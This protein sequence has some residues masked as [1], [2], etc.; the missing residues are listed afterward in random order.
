MIVYV[1]MVGRLPFGEWK[2]IEN[3]NSLYFVYL[4]SYDESRRDANPNGFSWEMC[5][6]NMYFFSEQKLCVFLKVLFRKN[7]RILFVSHKVYK[8]F[9]QCQGTTLDAKAKCVS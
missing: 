5:F 1:L 7:K 9:L 6:V 4:K 8:Y 2:H 3:Y